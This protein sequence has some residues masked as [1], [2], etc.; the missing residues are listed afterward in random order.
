MLKNVTKDETVQYVLALVEQLLAGKSCVLG[1]EWVGMSTRYMSLLRGAACGGT[2]EAAGGRCVWV[3]LGEIRDVLSSETG[4]A[5]CW[6]SEGQL[7]PCPPPHPHSTST[8]LRPHP[9]EQRTRLVP[10]TS[11][12]SPPLA[13]VAPWTPTK[14][15]CACCT[16]TTGSL[17][18]RP[19]C[20]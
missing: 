11:T 10:A 9:L 3:S 1:R 7:H 20:C 12:R 15:C 13:L 14:S 2:R 16:A 8:T 6:C 4:E 18:R 17:R 5:A 19:A